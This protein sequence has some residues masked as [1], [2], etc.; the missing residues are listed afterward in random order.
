M[1][2]HTAG[3]LLQSSTVLICDS[4]A[5][6]VANCT[7][8]SEIPLLA[9]PI[10]EVDANARRIVACWNACEGISDPESYIEHARNMVRDYGKLS[11]HDTM[12]THDRDEL[13][14]ALRIDA[15]PMLES[16]CKGDPR[17][18]MKLETLRT[19][20]ARHAPKVTT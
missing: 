7:P 1:S 3:R 15:M 6:V 19:L 17:T 14:E 20:L 2:E 4:E 8:I 16:Y 5:R 11:A 9:I 12:M 13:R 10:N 18:V